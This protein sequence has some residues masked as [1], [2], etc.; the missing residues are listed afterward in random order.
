M[1]TQTPSWETMTHKDHTL[2]KSNVNALQ[3][4]FT[5]LLKSSWVASGARNAA[6]LQDRAPACLYRDLF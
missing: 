2:E 4:S 6:R 1:L 3:N 5:I